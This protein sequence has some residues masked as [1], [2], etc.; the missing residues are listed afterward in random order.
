VGHPV[1][2]S[3]AT[4]LSH[5][6]ELLTGDALVVAVMRQQGLSDLTSNDADL[7]RVPGLRRYAP[8]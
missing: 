4:L 1:P 2:S 6:F 3:S 7:D 8:V 5:Q